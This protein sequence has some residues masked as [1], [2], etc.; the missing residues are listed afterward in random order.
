MIT[1]ARA[2]HTTGLVNPQQAELNVR[3]PYSLM[4]TLLS[5]PDGA[6]L[7]ALTLIVSVLA[8]GSRLTPPLAVPPSSWTWEVHVPPTRRSSDLAGV[9]SRSPSPAAGIDWPATTGLPR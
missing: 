7:T 1:A 2:S 6:S 8:L 3:L 4:V 9:N 5:L